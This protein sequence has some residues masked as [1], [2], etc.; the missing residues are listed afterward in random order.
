MDDIEK[1]MQGYR[2]TTAEITYHLP[3]H[4]KILQTFLWQD[5]DIP[6][7]FVRLK[8]FLQ[9]W[10]RQIE[11]RIHSVMVAH[12]ELIRPAAMQVQYGEYRLQ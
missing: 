11:G 2:L 1:Q 10:E 4:P 9:F 5:L 7:E 12:A 6:P 8:K 3:D